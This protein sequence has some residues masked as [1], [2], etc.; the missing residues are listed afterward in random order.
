MP[1]DREDNDDNDRKYA[2]YQQHPMQSRHGEEHAYMYYMSK[3]TAN[4][5]TFGIS[6]AANYE[7]QRGLRQMNHYFDLNSL[8]TALPPA[9]SST[10]TA[11]KPTAAQIKFYKDQK[12]KRKRIKNKWLYD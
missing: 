6:G 8:P 7:H 10:E 12:E 2:Q 5:E 3:A 1:A 4:P 9:S 11:E